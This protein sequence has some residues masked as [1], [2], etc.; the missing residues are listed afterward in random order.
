MFW[1]LLLLFKFCIH[2]EL[3]TSLHYLT[4][5]KVF[6]FYF[7]SS[8]EQADDIWRKRSG[9]SRPDRALPRG[10][11]HRFEMHR[12]GRFG[13]S[14]FQNLK[15]LIVVLAIG[16]FYRLCRLACNSFWKPEQS[17]IT[18]EEEFSPGRGERFE[19]TTVSSKQSDWIKKLR[20]NYNTYLAKY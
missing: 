9:G 13:H 12:I 15:C 19:L 1:C 8:A 10:W 11:H 7:S 6:N 16:T 4:M 2:L 3:S 14:K 18:S 20:I 5:S 17:F